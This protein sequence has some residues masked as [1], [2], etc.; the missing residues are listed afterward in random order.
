MK[1]GQAYCLPTGSAPLRFN[2]RL[3]NSTDFPLADDTD[4]GE[5]S[6]VDIAGPDSEIWQSGMAVAQIRRKTNESDN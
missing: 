4:R 6:S 2:I 1:S 5:Q 3:K